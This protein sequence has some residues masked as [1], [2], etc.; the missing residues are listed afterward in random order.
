[1]DYLWTN[2]IENLVYVKVNEGRKV[3]GCGWL[4]VSNLFSQIF[5]F[6]FTTHYN[7]FTTKKFTQR[8]LQKEKFTQRE[9]RKIGLY[10]V[11]TNHS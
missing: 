1:M 10:N 9:K 6:M 5:H 2:Q 7:G 11:K 3:I 4:N 8:F